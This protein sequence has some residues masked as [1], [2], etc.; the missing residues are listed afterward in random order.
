MEECCAVFECDGHLIA[1]FNTDAKTIKVLT[2]DGKHEV[3]SFSA[4]NCDRKQGF[5]LYDQGKFFFLK[6][7]VSGYST[8]Q[9]YISLTLERKDLVTGN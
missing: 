6:L 9:E 4:P 2:P 8:A 3:Q 5:V 1:C 7:I